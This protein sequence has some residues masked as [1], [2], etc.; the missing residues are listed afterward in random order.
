MPMP[1]HLPDITIRDALL[2]VALG[3]GRRCVFLGDTAF[4]IDALEPKYFF[5]PT[6][7]ELRFSDIEN[8]EPVDNIE[9]D[10]KDWLLSPRFYQIAPGHYNVVFFV[11]FF[12]VDCEGV[13]ILY[14]MPNL[15]DVPVRFLAPGYS[16]TTVHLTLS[17]D[18]HSFRQ[19]NV[20]FHSEKVKTG[21]KAPMGFWGSKRFKEVILEKSGQ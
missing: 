10:R 2:N 16:P 13:T 14:D 20:E 12:Y 1:K 4:L 9:V 5:M 21:E 17:G 18:E 3:L 15:R 7:V 11:Q 19:Y 8:G 6:S